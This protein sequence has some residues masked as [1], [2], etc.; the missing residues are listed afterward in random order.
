MWTSFVSS[1]FLIDGAGCGQKSGYSDG[2]CLEGRNEL[3]EMKS[4]DRRYWSD[5]QD[6]LLV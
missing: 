2:L 1:E 5:V 3:G 4:G 6:V